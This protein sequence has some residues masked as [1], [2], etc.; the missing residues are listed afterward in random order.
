MNLGPLLS[1]AGGSQGIRSSRR[2]NSRKRHKILKTMN[3]RLAVPILMLLLPV[4]SLMLSQKRQDRSQ[5][6]TQTTFLDFADGT[7]SDGGANTYVAADGS[8]RLINQWDLNGDGFLDPAFPSSHDNNYGVDSYIYWGRSSFAV[9]ARTHLPGNG[10][11]AQAMADLNGDGFLDVVIANAFNGTKTELLSFVYWGSARGFDVAKRTELPSVAVTAVAAAD[12][13][14]DG[15]LEL[16]FASSG[17]SYQ[18]S[19][20]GGDFTFLRPVSDVYW[21]SAQGFSP[22]RVAQ[23]PTVHARDV[24]VADL[25]RDGF[26]DLIF[27][28]HGEEPSQSGGLIYW[29]SEKGYSSDDNK[30]LPGVGTAAV[31]TA[32]VDADGYRDLLLA[33]E[34]KPNPDPEFA[35]NEDYPLPSF[36]YWGSSEGFDASRRAELPTAGARDVQVADLNGDGAL[37]IVFA[38]GVGKAS[39]IYWGNRTRDLQ[40][41]RMALPTRHASRCA[42]GDLNGDE[43]PE[44]VF[45]QEHNGKTNECSS[46][47]YW[48]S[49]T[50]FSSGKITK[51]PTLGALDVG[52]ADL[53]RDGRPDLLFANAR[54]GTAGQ[55]VDNYIYWGNERGEYLPAARQVLPGDA[56]TAYSSADLDRNGWVDLIVVG[57]E[58]RIFW[59]SSLGFSMSRSQTLPVT[60]AFSTR[61]AD[62]DKDGYLD[63]SASDWQGVP[64]R[65]RTVIFWGSAGGYSADHRFTFPFAGARAHAVGDLDGNGYLD[66]VFAGTFNETA[67]FWNTPSGFNASKKSVLP[68]KLAVSAEVADLNRDGFL[69][70][71]ICNLYD[72]DKLVRAREVAAITAPPQTETFRA[73]TWIYWGSPRGYSPERRLEL[74]TIGSEDAGVADLNDDSYLDLVVT[75]Y[76]AGTTRNHPSYIFWGSARGI[77]AA[78]VTEL[79]TESASGVLVADLNQ[80]RWKDIL[81]ACHTEG[82]NHRTN[83]FLYWGSPGGFLKQRKSLIPS[84]GTHWLSVADVGNVRDRSDDFDYVS[85]PYDAGEGA[86]FTKLLWKA[87]TPAK[88]QIKFQLRCA[89]DRGALLKSPWIGPQGEGT[90]YRQPGL[91][92]P[93]IGRWIQYKAILSSPNGANSPVLDSVIV[94]Y[95]R[96][97]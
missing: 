72:P 8:I 28:N 13:N 46:I 81:F 2:L 45:S 41:R 4:A 59:G 89:A 79:Q 43:R 48:N 15:Y 90:F 54:D 40:A 76:H 23:L 74:P 5:Q 96:E 78:N 69:D 7:L 66:L 61:I 88:T 14:R 92:L 16:V 27:A 30:L 65:D 36:I 6:W 44:L 60:Y 37:D 71:I 70:I 12:L 95:D 84:K 11:N 50:G 83:S 97:H 39:F 47:V 57:R 55:P 53:D 75:S 94:Q 93:Q 64:D 33:N 56:L 21:G 10:A 22:E 24:A 62:F 86:R 49:A 34:R 32:D 38:N 9:S 25:N 77:D 91:I 42:I 31:A 82:T 18:F 68:C 20:S 87:I 63:I 29:G 1:D 26:Q 52:I 35:G 67:I 17:R 85:R 51:L 19:K 73:G 3:L 58:L 80:D